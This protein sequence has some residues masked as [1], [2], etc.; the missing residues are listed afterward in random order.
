MEAFRI[1]KAAGLQTRRTLRLALW[2]GERTGLLGSRA[3]VRAHLDGDANKA[4]AIGS[5]CI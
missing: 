3:Y 1:L 4:D 2:S 5:R